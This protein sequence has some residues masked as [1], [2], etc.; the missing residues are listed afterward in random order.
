MGDKARP[1]DQISVSDMIEFTNMVIAN[2][3]TDSLIA[4]AAEFRGLLNRQQNIAAIKL[5][6][7]GV[8][9]AREPPQLCGK[10]GAVLNT[11]GIGR[12]FET[13]ID[14]R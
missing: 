8:K 7:L 10:G 12:Q 3:A 4:T 1:P 11:S 2:P 9:R 13:Q 14:G 6:R 5:V